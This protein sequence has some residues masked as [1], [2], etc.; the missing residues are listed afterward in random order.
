MVVIGMIATDHPKIT[1]YFYNFTS[2]FPVPGFILRELLEQK[3]NKNIINFDLNISYILETR[4]NIDIKLRIGGSVIKSISLD[5]N[6]ISNKIDEKALYIIDKTSGK[7]YKAETFSSQGYL[8]IFISNK[9]R[10][11][12]LNING[13]HM[14]QISRFSPYKDSEKKVQYAKIKPGERVLDICTGLGYTAIA[15][16]LK[17][18]GQVVTIEINRYILDLAGANPWSYY[19]GSKRIH[20]IN[21]DALR[22]LPLF[23]DGV[24]DKAIHDPPRFSIAGELYSLDFYREIYRVLRP[25]G[26][27]FHYTGQ[28]MRN[29]GRGLGPI[30]RGIRSRLEKAGFIVLRYVDDVYGFIAVKPR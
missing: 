19:L 12:T 23:R 13:I 2:S 7:I 14:H 25:G 20:I 15:A 5:I 10:S 30:V 9:M 21:D 18:A 4:N 3:L 22:V 26:I 1:I 24:F 6:N 11:S 27:L 16:L 8:K 29:R 28:P 17:G